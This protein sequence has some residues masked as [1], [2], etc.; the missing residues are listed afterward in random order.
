MTRGHRYC[1]S[2]CYTIRMIV[3]SSILQKIYHSEPE[4]GQLCFQKK[5]GIDNREKEKGEQKF[6]LLHSGSLF[7]S[8]LCHNREPRYEVLNGH[9]QLYYY[10][11][12][13][14]YSCLYKYLIYIC[15]S[16]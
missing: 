7:L 2:H 9:N 14:Y 13:I 3:A 16:I 8:A 1:F 15:Y 10:N 4:L 5:R 11:I 12:I 6:V